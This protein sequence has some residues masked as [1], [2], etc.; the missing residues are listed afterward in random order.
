M[1]KNGTIKVE[2]KEQNYF[3]FWPCLPVQILQCRSN[4]WDL[5]WLVVSF[6]IL[7]FSSVFLGVLGVS[8]ETSVTLGGGSS[9]QEGEK[10]K[11]SLTVKYAV[12]QSDVWH[13]PYLFRF[14]CFH[15]FLALNFNF[16]FVCDLS[17]WSPLCLSL[18]FFNHLNS[19]WNEKC[20][21]NE[22]Y[23]LKEG[24]GWRH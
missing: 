8:I 14:R 19:L 13:A 7:L 24:G 18:L 22:G 20:I 21:A 12:T 17:D 11:H 4:K 2:C 5:C 3:I 1:Q 16:P 15:R 9:W 23:A 10:L 6:S